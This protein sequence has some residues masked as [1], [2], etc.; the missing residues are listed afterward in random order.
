M[1]VVRYGEQRTPPFRVGPDVYRRDVW[2]PS[3]ETF[4]PVQMCHVEV[5]DRYRAVSYTHLTLP[6]TPYV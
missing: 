3:L 4:L 2:Q 1:Y 5:R 6:T